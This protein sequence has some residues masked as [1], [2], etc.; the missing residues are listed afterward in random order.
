PVVRHPPWATVAE[1]RME[2]LV[3]A[4]LFVTTLA[5]YAYLFVQGTDFGW[6]ATVAVP[7]AVPAGNGT[8]QRQVPALTLP[9]PSARPD[10]Y[11]PG[12]VP[13]SYDDLEISFLAR[14]NTQRSG[15]GLQPL[16]ASTVLNLLADIRVRQMIDQ[17]YVGHVDPYGYTMYVELLNLYAISYSDAGEIVGRTSVPTND[18]SLDIL[19]AFMNSPEHRADI[20]SADFTLVGVAEE[21]SLDGAHDFAAIFLN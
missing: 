4:A 12:I 11:L 8:T 3:I 21:D 10:F 1:M 6:G 19:T 13:R 18:A 17:G 20:L 9:H 7:T 15:A 2:A 5:M 14:L 16:Q